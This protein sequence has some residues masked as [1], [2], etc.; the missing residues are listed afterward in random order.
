[1]HYLAHAA[2][3]HHY[4]HVVIIV[5]LPLIR[6]SVRTFFRRRS[7]NVLEDERDHTIACIGARWSNLILWVGLLV[8]MTLYWDH[9]MHSAGTLNGLIF[10]L[11]L[12]AGVVSH[13]PRARRAQDNAA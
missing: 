8:I 6:V 10:H 5:V 11:L 1:M 4:F 3:G 13:H 12:P 7:K 9:G 2:P